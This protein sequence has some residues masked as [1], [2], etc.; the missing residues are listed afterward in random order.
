MSKYVVSDHVPNTPSALHRVRRMMPM[1]AL[2][3]ALIWVMLWA[4][5]EPSRVRAAI[6]PPFTPDFTDTGGLPLQNFGFS[7]ASAGDIDNDGFGDVI[8]GAN[9]AGSAYVYTGSL[10]GLSTS[11]IFTATGSPDDQFG[12][13]VA[14]GGDL[15]GDGI[16]DFVVGAPFSTTGIAF[17]YHGTNLGLPTLAVTLTGELADDR[18]GW[19]VD[20]I[21]DVNQDGIDDLAIGA[22]EYGISN[23]GRAYIY[24]GS[25]TGIVNA[26]T[27]TLN[28]E[29]PLDGFGV[30]VAAAGDVNGDGF[31]DLAVGAWKNEAGGT[32]AGK[33]YVFYGS[34][35]GLNQAN[36]TAVQGSA[37]DKFGTSVHGAGDVN[38]DGFDDLIVGIDAYDP[39]NPSLGRAEVYPGGPLGLITTALFTAEGESDNDRFGFAVGGQG[40]INGDGFGD[41]AVGA[42]Q[43]DATMPLSAT[44]KSYGYAGCVGDISPNLT[45]SATGEAAFDNYGR[46]LAI[47]DDVNG[48][49]VDDIVIGAFGAVL[50][51]GKIYAYYGVNSG[52]CR[53]QVELTKTIGLANYPAIY[54][55]TTVITVPM[56]TV[57]S[58]QYQ[59]RNTGNLTLT[60]H[61]VTDSALGSLSVPTPFTLL[62]GISTTFNVTYT[63]DVSVT[64]VATWTSALSVTSPSG[65]TTP[66]NRIISDSAV[67]SATVRISGLTTDQDDDSIPDNVETSNDL[68]RDGIPNYLDQ[69]SDNDGFPDSAE[70]G[71]NPNSPIDRDQDGIPGYLDPDENPNTPLPTE[72]VD[73]LAQMHLPWLRRQR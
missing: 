3:G 47:V 34:S 31:D 7:V 61:S 43:F 53:A 14:G 25:A 23:T 41:F 20:I 15:N 18:F 73:P 12:Y 1:L 45:F 44:G 11:A 36:N 56:G 13:S 55:N 2:G 27:T 51:T 48:D 32:E 19:S 26:S 60:Q 66:T 69:D 21:G 28:G 63:P 35:T 50:S 58:Y 37:N 65:V 6:T 57:V 29:A 17:V 40:D 52:G 5:H 54:T 70:V 24:H 42:Y 38:G 46:S 68:D 49:G 67:A 4:L 59:V 16:D 62:P 64:N 30:S 71:L 72:P 39:G 33:A 9:L 8:V 22:S 10:S